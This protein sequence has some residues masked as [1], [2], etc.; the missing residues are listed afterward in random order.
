M[1]EPEVEE[2]V[3]EVDYAFPEVF[4]KSPSE[5]LGEHPDAGHK[6]TGRV[7]VGVRAF[8]LCLNA[9]YDLDGVA[10]E[11]GRWNAHA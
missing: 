8:E 5:L 2:P 3:D 1:T 11:L 9:L 7:L 4:Q 10:S 6:S